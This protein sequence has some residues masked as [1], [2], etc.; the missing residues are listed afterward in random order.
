MMESIIKTENLSKKFGSKDI[1]K[2][3]NLEIGEG[4]IFALIG[5]AHAG[6]T[7]LLLT[8]NGFYRPSLGRIYI[9]GTDLTEKKTALRLN[10]GYL[11]QRAG[12]YELMTAAENLTFFAGLYGFSRHE[13]A[14]IVRETLAY[15]FL[16]EYA[17]MRVKTFT[18]GM[19]QRLGLAKALIHQPKVL[20]LD[21]PH[22]GLD[23][24]EIEVLHRL[25]RKLGKEK[26]TVLLSAGSLSAVSGLC[27]HIGVILAGEMVYQGPMEHFSDM[28]KNRYRKF[29]LS[30]AT[31]HSDVSSTEVQKEEKICPKAQVREISQVSL[32]GEVVPFLQ[33]EHGE[34]IEQFQPGEEAGQ[35]IRGEQSEHAANADQLLSSVSPDIDNSRLLETC[36]ELIANENILQTADSTGSLHAGLTKSPL[37]GLGTLGLAIIDYEIDSVLLLSPFEDETLLTLLNARGIQVLGIT[38]LPVTEEELY[39]HYCRQQKKLT[40]KGGAECGEN[41]AAPLQ[42]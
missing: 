37:E 22:T 15:V 17:D 6:K 7:T 34:Q 19:L 1:L 42:D 33:T 9:S 28:L 11:P 32:D 5:P 16:D 29:K 2:N 10:I 38:E 39:L 20:L 13:I 35:L 21:E 30:L 14:R 23:P 27:T 4:E 40:Q 31:L 26:R 24:E 25:V 18:P 3:V 36:E 8:L 41:S 12:F